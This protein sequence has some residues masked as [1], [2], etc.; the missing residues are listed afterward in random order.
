MRQELDFSP[1]ESASAISLAGII[2]SSVEVYSLLRNNAISHKDVFLCDPQNYNAENY[3]FS[4]KFNLKNS[5]IEP[6]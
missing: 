1:F 3:I 5:V 6:R 4:Q 2:L